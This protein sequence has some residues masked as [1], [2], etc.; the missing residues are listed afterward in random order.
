[1]RKNE[2]IAICMVLAVIG[3]FIIIGRSPTAETVFV[4]DY[5][6]DYGAVAVL[7]FEEGTGEVTYDQSSFGNHGTI[8]GAT[9]APGKFGMALTFDGDDYVNIF[10]SASLD[11]SDHITIEA[12][13][14]DPPAATVAISPAEA[15]MYGYQRKG[16]HAA[17]LFW[18]F[19]TNGTDAGWETSA[20]GTTWTGAFTSI[21]AE[22][23]GYGF[24][25]SVWFD[26]TYIHYARI[27]YGGTYDT[28]YRRGTPVNDGTI[29]WS[30]VEQTV[31]DGSLGDNYLYTCITVD[32]N[33][34]AWIG[35][36]YDKPD[37]NNFP[38]VLKNSE[39]DGTWTTEVGFDPYE[40][41]AVNSSLWFAGPVPLTGG[42]VY[43]IYCIS[44][45]APLGKLYDAGWGTEESDL[46]DYN[47]A[48]GWTFCAVALDDNVHLVYNRDGTNQIRH[49]ERVWG[50]GWNVNDV[51]VQDAVDMFCGPALSVIPSTGDLY[52]F[53]TDWTTD[54]V[55]YKQY[56]GGAWGGLVDWINEETDDIEYDDLISSYY[57][58]YG[59]YVGLLYV[60]GTYP[61]N[62]RF[63]FLTMPVHK[64]IVEKIDAYA[65]CIDD[66]N[67]LY[68]QINSTRVSYTVDDITA[69]HYY[70]MTYDNVTLSLLV[71][72]EVVNS[73]ALTGSIALNDNDVTIGTRFL[74]EIDQIRIY[75]VAK[76]LGEIRN[77]YLNSGHMYSGSVIVSDDFRILNTSLNERIGLDD[78]GL[79]LNH[80]YILESDFSHWIHFTMAAGITDDSIN[81]VPSG[82]LIQ[83]R[84]F[85]RITFAVDSAPG[86]G[87][88]CNVTLTDGVGTMSVSITG[89][90]TDG[91]T[92]TGEFDWDVSDTTL[93]LRYTQDAGG[94][95]RK[96]FITVKYHYQ[97]T[98]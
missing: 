27:D 4:E 32:T 66:T 62:L 39:N 87:K 31:H 34:Y 47:I 98:P 91:W 52:C 12:W 28:Y 72:G 51:L 82:L 53:W 15:V 18:A 22:A 37:G 81:V 40:L 88:E 90:D 85:H 94:L 96:G 58:D 1:M 74:G 49:N 75:S 16:F 23:Y 11:I 65:L 78:S 13:A 54:H 61:Y 38:V 55:Y 95:A 2:A 7:N 33:G 70:S 68:G 35:A 9:W 71:D 6:T 3:S 56:T 59:S 41:S 21:G 25:F 45:A 8:I 83:D 84:H 24:A 76:T 26:G 20:D 80:Y 44:E 79:D 19:Y 97:E 46:A 64:V 69:W 77:H 93:T 86:I 67:I 50:V 36:Q 10:D 29:N 43:V 14:K 92:E 89:T 60:T 42:K 30:A 48:D 5:G 73:T 17:G 57:M 63:A